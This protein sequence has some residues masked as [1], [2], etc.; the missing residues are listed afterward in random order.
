MKNKTLVLLFIIVV[1]LACSHGKNSTTDSAISFTQDTLHLGLLMR[2]AKKEGKFTFTNAKVDSI[3]I[4][5]VKSSCGCVVPN[6]TK[7]QLYI[8]EIGEINFKVTAPST[9]GKFMEIL[10]AK[11]DTSPFL[12]TFYIVGEVG[13]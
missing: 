8:N 13:N 2:E 6:Y 9:S 1:I 10:V 5:D 12:K 3:R 11:F 4:L 7:K